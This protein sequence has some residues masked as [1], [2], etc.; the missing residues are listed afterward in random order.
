MDAF[1]HSPV[2]E[3]G[4]VVAAPHQPVGGGTLEMQQI[5]I[6]HIIAS[7]APRQARK[8]LQRVCALCWGIC[9]TIKGT[10]PTFVRNPTGLYA[11]IH[12]CDYACNFKFF[13]FFEKLI[14]FG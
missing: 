11:A 6:D 7:G 14:A 13:P 4:T 1:P 8:C 5:Q 12:I 3:H 9:D 10:H 2:H